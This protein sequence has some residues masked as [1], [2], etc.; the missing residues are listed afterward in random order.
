VAAG[1]SSKGD[2]EQQKSALRSLLLSRLRESEEQSLPLSML[3]NDER[4]QGLRKGFGSLRKVLRL[5]EDAIEL[6]E[7]GEPPE[8][9]ARLLPLVA[10]EAAEAEVPPP[11]P[12]PARPSAVPSPSTMA[13]GQASPS[14]A[15]VPAAQLPAAEVHDWS[16]A[17]CRVVAIVERRAASTELVA[18]LQ[19]PAAAGEDAGSGAASAARPLK[20]QP[21]DTRL[22]AFWVEESEEVAFSSVSAASAGG[23]PSDGGK[24]G[25]QK[26]DL[27]HLGAQLAAQE[28]GVR[29]LS[30]AALLR[31]LEN[32]SEAGGLLCVVKFTDWPRTSLSPRAE[33]VQVLGP[34]GTVSAESD[35]L[36]SFYG[37]DWR[38][39][40]E[41]VEKSLRERFPDSVD[42][43]RK[44]LAL[45][46]PDLRELRCITI[47]PATAKDLDDAVSVEPGKVQG[48]Y[49]VGV[50]VADVTHFVR[51]GDPIDSL[52]RERATTVYLVGRV[53]PMLP[54]WLSENLCSLLP[55][56][57]RLA[58]SVFFTLDMEG[59][60]LTDL[61]PPT[62][63]RAVIRT[64]CRLNYNEVDLALQACEDSSLQIPARIAPEVLSDIKALAAITGARRKLRID[65]GAVV[66]DRSHFW[67]QTDD[68]G[69][70]QGVHKEGANSVS[71]SLIEELMVLA[72][73][74]VAAKLVEAG[75]AAALEAG[76]AAAGCEAALPQPLLRRHPDTEDDVRQ[77]IFELLPANLREE[78]PQDATLPV[79]LAWCKQRWSPQT[80]EAV[81]ADVLTAFKEAEYIV[82]EEDDAETLEEKDEQDVGHWALSLP[83]YMHFT[84]PIRRYADIL[85]HRRLNHILGSGSEAPAAQPSGPVAHSDFLEGLKLAVE[86]CNTKKRDA[87]DASL[88]SIQL[89]LSAYVQRSGGVDVADAVVTRILLPSSASAGTGPPATPSSSSAEPTSGSTAASASVGSGSPTFRQKLKI[90]VR[91][92]AMEFY[93]PM[94]QC[95]RSVS[96]EALGIELVPDSAVLSEPGPLAAA[97]GSGPSGSTN[98][99]SVRVRVRG[100]TGGS[101]AGGAAGEVE[102]QVLEPVAVRLVSEGAQ[103]AEGGGGAGDAATPRHWTVRLPWAVSLAPPGSETGRQA[104]AAAAAAPPPGPPPRPPPSPPPPPGTPSP[105]ERS[106]GAGDG[107][108]RRRPAEAAAA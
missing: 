55:D 56:G 27:R 87:Q 64:A 46:R 70:I 13:G 63:C 94:A 108:G 10:A 106:V 96:F 37:L 93:I 60:L 40:P 14:I 61:E 78:A 79:L 65:S 71:H 24:G 95:S 51:P 3:G 105:R 8:L 17:R 75:K 29:S 47:D 2:V 91:K 16:R 15:A 6:V 12:L 21:R 54:H 84:S 62:M 72:N 9:V 18:L 1:G 92:E 89:A 83:T 35:A 11:P 90:R 20:V 39:F 30:K 66:L 68:D 97:G 23:V 49:R 34:T 28:A 59:R 73:H 101:A 43:V 38:P 74:V 33:V 22:P 98:A 67:F 32:S 80:H 50:H 7:E 85:V 5:F 26:R 48:T 100:T 4:V 69:R 31:A 58:M 76:S 36:L 42:V 107:A 25:K 99:R 19:A 52:A 41:V 104:E 57:D 53:Y 77:R 44:E 102:I 103:D 82:A 86:R 88:D 45:G 81:C